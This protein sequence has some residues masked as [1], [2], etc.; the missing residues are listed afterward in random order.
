MTVSNSTFGV[1]GAV[2]PA[3]EEVPVA[4]ADPTGTFATGYDTGNATILPG[5]PANEVP[6]P[7]RCDTDNYY[8]TDPIDED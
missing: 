3:G 5:D 1:T 2:T 6:M 8:Y 7:G 4:F